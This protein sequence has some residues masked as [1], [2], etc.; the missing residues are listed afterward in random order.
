MQPDDYLSL[1]PLLGGLIALHT[2]WNIHRA[3]RSRHW[4]WTE[5]HLQGI[6]IRTV[7][8]LQEQYLRKA[9]VSQHLSADY[10]YQV[11]GR[12]YRGKRVTMSDGLVKPRGELLRIIEDYANRQHCRV[13]YNPLD[14]RQS[15]LIPGFR[16]LQLAPFLTAAAFAALPMVF[17]ALWG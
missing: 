16:M 10:T 8:A 9:W 2:L 1:F 17:Q 4:P 6:D 7:T 12:N 3:W 14:P 5:G 11:D 15:C 13:Y